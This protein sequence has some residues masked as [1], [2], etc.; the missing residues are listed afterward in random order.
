MT[1]TGYSIRPAIGLESVPNFLFFPL[2]W[3][4]ARYTY[5]ETGMADSDDNDDFD[6]REKALEEIWRA[7][8]R[9]AAESLRDIGVLMINLSEI[10]KSDGEENLPSD[11]QYRFYS[12]CMS[13][14]KP[15]QKMRKHSPCARVLEWESLEFFAVHAAVVLVNNQNNCT[16]LKLP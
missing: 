6:A 9:R 1:C 7:D 11:R 5:T 16:A 14:A 3:L 2:L 8:F 13:V 4:L 10:M 15:A 12:R